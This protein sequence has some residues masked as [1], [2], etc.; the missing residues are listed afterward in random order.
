AGGVAVVA[1]SW[2][3]A[4][5]ARAA[6]PSEWDYGPRAPQTSDTILAAHLASL[7]QPGMV[8]TNQGDVEAGFKSAAKIVE[9]TYG[10]P[11]CSKARFEPGAATVLVSD[12]RVDCWLG[13]Q[14]PENMLSTAAKMTGV[15]PENVYVHLTFMGGGYGSDQ[16]GHPSQAVA[17]AMAM[18]GRPVQLRVSREEDWSVGTRFRPMGV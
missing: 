12:D 7:N 11:Y 2:W 13:T 18:K 4:Q 16:G 6:M 3:R 15:K 10:I 8:W 9:A 14:A 1:D 17:I 5:T